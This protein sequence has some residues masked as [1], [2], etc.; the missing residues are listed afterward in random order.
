MCLMQNLA[1]GTQTSPHLV[2]DVRLKEHLVFEAEDEPGS[3]PGEAI[4]D[5]PAQNQIISD[6]KF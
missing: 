3:K 6:V 2:E 1:S 5:G 4:E